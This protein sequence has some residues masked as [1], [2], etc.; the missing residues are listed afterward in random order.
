VLAA[1]LAEPFRQLVR[2]HGGM[3]P[4]LAL[5]DAERLGCGVG[6]D[7]LAGELGNMRERGILDSVRVT[8]GALQTAVS[9]AI[10]L[11]T[12]SVVILP[13]DAKREQRPK[14]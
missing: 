13:A 9:G 8:K 5:A 1:A 10:A 4:L 14:P 2:N 7:V 12:T 6:F 3:P 11:L